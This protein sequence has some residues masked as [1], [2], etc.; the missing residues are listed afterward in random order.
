MN[1]SQQLSG[2]ATFIYKITK[3]VRALWLA[4]RRV[5]RR[6]CKHG[7]DVKIFCFLCANHT[8]TNLKTKLS[9]KLDKST[10]FTHSLVG[11]NLENLYK[12]AVS[13]FFRLSWHCKR[14]K[15]LFWKAS[16]SQNKN[17][18]RVQDLVYKTLRLV[19][20]SLL[21][22]AIIKCFQFFSG[23]LIYKS[24]RNLFSCICIA[25]YKHFVSG[26]HNCFEFSHEYHW[27][28]EPVHRYV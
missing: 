25:W 8:G 12:H 9:W 6:V 27:Q 23:E 16:F 19:R 10:L 7:C 1:F 11:R 3:I 21:I 22:S 26:W 2:I 13:I 20:I 15:S 24:D 14:E 4:E 5:C 28:G 18:L 17:W